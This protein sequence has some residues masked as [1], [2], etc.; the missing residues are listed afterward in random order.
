MYRNCSNLQAW[1][2][3]KYDL[4]IIHTNLGFPL[5]KKLAE[6]DKNALISLKEEIAYRVEEIGYK[7]FKIHENIINKFFTNEEKSILIT[8]TKQQI[9]SILEEN[10]Y[11]HKKYSPYSIFL[12]KFCSKEEKELLLI[13]LKESIINKI[14]DRYTAFDIHSFL[15]RNCTLCKGVFSK[16]GYKCT[17][18]TQFSNFDLRLRIIIPKEKFEDLKVGHLSFQTLLRL[19]GS[20]KTIK[21]Y[22]YWKK[23]KL[24][25]KIFPT[26][27]NNFENYPTLKG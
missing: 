18:C 11:D 13:S 15:I 24:C 20:L 27:I 16:L 1:V 21:T 19:Y 8:Q 10:Q 26:K 5:L 23:E 6:F 14:K 22:N 17:T 4:R 25:Q 12:N 7:A 3:N 2:E 9:F